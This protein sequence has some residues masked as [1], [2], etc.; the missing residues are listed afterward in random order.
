VDL[1]TTGVDI[2]E[3]CNLVFARR[4]NSRIL[5]D[6]MIG[7]ATRRADH[8]G[9]EFFRIFDAVDIYA[10]LQTLTDMRPVV[11]NPDV[12]LATLI[13][14]LGRAPTEEDRAFVR[15]QIVV[16]LRRI[17]R[18]LTD[19]QRAAYKA[20]DLLLSIV[21]TIGKV[22]VVPDA[23]SGGNITQ[24]SCRIRASVHLDPLYV[25]HFLKSPI[26][27]AQYEAVRLGTAVPR[28]NVADVRRLQVPLAPG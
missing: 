11:T 24:S 26:A 25:R 21:G 5:Y 8:I 20:G 22:A 19:A 2:P 27:V 28:L 1:L 7:R 12:P 14:D 10:N 16:R 17:I 9:K 15:D 23:L 3:I 4:I 18:H 6:Q 13:A